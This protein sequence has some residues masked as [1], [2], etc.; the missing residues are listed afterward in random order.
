MGSMRRRN[1][2]VVTV[3]LLV[4]VPLAFAACSGPDLSQVKLPKVD[5]GTLVTPNFNEFQKREEARGAVGPADL[6]D[7]SGRCAD[8]GGG[9][10][11]DVASGGQG[12][13]GTASAAPT[14]HPIALKMTECQVVAVT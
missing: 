10:R 4:A 7:A 9:Q 2:Q 5:A 8:S 3:A 1:E 13:E 12:G 6:V 14:L 11:P